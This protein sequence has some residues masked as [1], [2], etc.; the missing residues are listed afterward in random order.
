[1]GGDSAND[2]VRWIRTLH[3]TGAVGA[4][5]DA[6]L[7]ERFAGREGTD[8]EDAFSALVHRHGP[9]VQRVCRRMLSDPADADDAF[10][11]VFLVLA[12]KAGSLRRAED[13][14]S[15][16][17][18]VAVRTSLEA[19]K[20]AARLR[21]REGARLDDSRLAVAPSNPLFE[22]RSLLDEELNR[23]PNRLREPLL[24]CELEGVSRRE[25]ARRL[26]LP[27]GTL[28][29]RLARGRVMLRDRLTR[30]GVAVAALGAIFPAPAKAGSLGALADASTRLALK[31]A[32]RDA[33][34]GSV[35][36]AVASLAEGVL[37]MFQAA[38]LKTVLLATST[39]VAACLT[40]GLAWG[41]VSGDDAPKSKAE[42]RA[43]DAKPAP[44]MLRGVVA[45]ESG[46][47]VAGAEI[48]ANPFGVLE[49][50]GVSDAEG[51]FA[52]ALPV[53]L[54]GRPL[55]LART[56]DDRGLGVFQS[57][58][59]DTA[60][61]IVVK[62]GREVVAKV[63]DEDG[64]PIAD[65]LV[66]VAGRGNGAKGSVHVL[67]HETTEAD[68]EAR[69]LIPVDAEVAWIVGKKEGRGLDFAEF[70]THAT[71]ATVARGTPAGAIPET[72]ALTLG[73]PRIVRIRA[74][75]DAGQP[76]V[77]IALYPGW[78]EKSGRRGMLNYS[79]RAFLETTDRDGVAVFD[80][81]PESP[82]P[83]GFMPTTDDY[84]HRLVM[85]NPGEDLTTIRLDPTVAIRGRVVLPDG[86]PAAGVTVLARGSGRGNSYGSG[87]ARTAA[88]GSYAMK[89]APNEGYAVWVD[90]DDRAAPA[91]LDVAVR[92]GEPVEDVEF[93]LGPG[94]LIHG[95]VSADSDGSPAPNVH[96]LLHESDGEVPADHR[97]KDD[98][99]RREF[100]RQLNAR[101]GDQ[102]RYAIRVGPGVYRVFA[103]A[104]QNQSQSQ[105]IAV[106][107]EADLTHDILVPKPAERGMLAGRVVGPDGRA[108][109]GATVK[110]LSA[111]ELRET[112][113][114]GRT[115][116]DGR[117]EAERA[118]HRGFVFAKS[119][120][121]SLGAVVPIGPG[122]ADV[123]VPLAPTTSIRGTLLDEMGEPAANQKLKLWSSYPTVYQGGRPLRAPT[124]MTSQLTPRAGSRHRGSSSGRFTRS[125]SSRGPTDLAES[126]RPKPGK[127][128][129]RSIWGRSKSAIVTSGKAPKSGRSPR[130]CRRRRPITA[131][132]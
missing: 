100:R 19:R 90:D 39:L 21:A 91:R 57:A 11:A 89:V 115:S 131:S 52:I 6:R 7:V 58:E 129:G 20:R 73:A 123:V 83:V 128:P 75:D 112:E 101:T 10:Q 126:A 78:V 41:F 74:V 13:L 120:D 79:T 28:S 121:G 119:L 36:A 72:T 51:A 69:L 50:R 130:S 2:L 106:T 88:D 99:R 127:P 64:K 4:L 71:P 97:E 37:L 63:A 98:P 44:I 17:Y 35:P 30:R 113:H 56:A 5:S 62:P 111:E 29:S 26:G 92:S 114:P 117:F 18:G 94:T 132:R 54:A 125:N 87:R 80:W 61:R 3:E 1:M 12:R 122:T 105:T 70:G 48:L 15:W 95:T 104:G 85:V 84:A 59:V 32:A 43:D 38:K 53:R 23:L 24:L 16:L 93:Q 60:I 107:N 118:L 8:R 34:A 66:E 22:L 81:L 68:G 110:I 47:P 86:S 46:E 27:E 49:S 40:A 108:L 9:M 77:G 67:T 124:I 45:D 116:A 109:A 55:L 33:A 42:A 96:V 31:F 102:G 82:A 14:K 76:V 103:S 65:A 25:A